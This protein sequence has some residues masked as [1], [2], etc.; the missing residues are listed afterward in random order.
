MFS[1]KCLLNNSGIWG[2]SNCSVI[3]HGIYSSDMVFNR[4]FPKVSKTFL[5]FIIFV[6]VGNQRCDY[7]WK[8][9][10][11]LKTLLWQNNYNTFSN[12]PRR[13][14]KWNESIL[15]R[16]MLKL[17]KKIKKPFV[18]TEMLNW[19]SHA[20]INGGKNSLSFHID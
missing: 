19:A 16:I 1:L 20:K 9:C 7:H 11:S 13:A 2:S 10:Q 5:S 3:R 4:I 18:I 6:I 12:S 14:R 15:D 17:N 8:Q